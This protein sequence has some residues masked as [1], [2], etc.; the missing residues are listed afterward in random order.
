V[1]FFNEI[2]DLCQERN[3]IDYDE[4]ASLAGLDDRIGKSH[5]QVPGPDGDRGFGGACFPKDTKAL[6]ATFQAN[7]LE[8]CILSSVI[9]ANNRIRN[10]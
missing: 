3:D 7:D 4:I 5:M 6:Q 8:P 10:P 9:R 1:A 2:Y